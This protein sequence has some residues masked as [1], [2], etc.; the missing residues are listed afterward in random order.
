YNQ[1]RKNVE[2]Q[3]LK[4][5]EE[6]IKN[7]LCGEHALV[8]GS[9]G[10][11]PGVLGIVASRLKDRYGRPSF[12]VSFDQGVAKGSGRST[13]EIHL[14]DMLDKCSDFLSSY[15]GH[16]KAVG[17]ELEEDNLDCFRENIN[18]VIKK[19]TDLKESLPI[20]EID[21]KLNFKQI[22]IELVK[23]IELLYP[24]GEGNP[25]PI[26]LAEGIAKK[27][28]IEK[29][30]YRYS[31]WLTDGQRT[32]EAIIYSKDLAEIMNYG[33]RFDIVFSLDRDNYHNSPR[34]SLRDCRLA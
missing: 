29:N 3:I 5:A 16:K 26:F 12:V 15:G 11:H 30:R 7:N 31:L 33:E 27:K 24:Y 9:S 6:I 8:L 25:K 17:M 22:N 14:I 34:L 1:L 23:D 4:E 21:A 28:G 32:F 18:A 10:W 2:K 20:L 13:E 19:D